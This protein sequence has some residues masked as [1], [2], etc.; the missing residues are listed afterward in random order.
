[1]QF[2]SALEVALKVA[3]NELRYRADV[4]RSFGDTPPV[5]VNEGRLSQVFLNLVVN[6]SQAF[7]EADPERNLVSV[8]TWEDG[9]QVVAEVRDNGPGIS[10][11]NLP[12]LFD[13]F[14]TTKPVGV[15]SGLGLSICHNIV[16][17]ADG[18]IEV[19]S[20]VGVGTAFRVRLPR[21][22]GTPLVE[23][24]V[25]V[26]SVTTGEFPRSLEDSGVF[27]SPFGFGFKARAARSSEAPPASTDTTR[28]RVLVVDDEPLVAAAIGRVLRRYEVRVALSGREALEQIRTNGPWDAIVSDL[29]MDDGSGMELHQWLEEGYPD[30]ALRTLFLTGGAFTDEAR[31]FLQEIPNPWLEKP[32]QPLELRAAVERLAKTAPPRGPGTDAPDSV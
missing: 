12:R 31:R 24:R 25:P 18:S 32:V 28:A 27:P 6:A 22:P 21:A 14:F 13:P 29:M 8:S 9:D 16:R 17:S 30:L 2:E 7:V 4:D 11:A 5:L 3:R 23:K 19:E 26:M 1:M 10:A 20:E 15:G